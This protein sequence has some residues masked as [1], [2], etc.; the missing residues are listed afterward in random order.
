MT[1]PLTDTY[2]SA[3][4]HADFLVNTIGLT[5][6]PNITAE[7]AK[8]LVENLDEALDHVFV[9]GSVR[10]KLWAAAKQQATKHGIT[11]NVQGGLLVRSSEPNSPAV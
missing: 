5:Q 1:S 6:I 11:A 8:Q 9:Q 7:Q 10:N 2:T 4:S 3:T